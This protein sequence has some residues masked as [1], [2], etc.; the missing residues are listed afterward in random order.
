MTTRHIAKC[1]V[2]A[3]AVQNG[4]TLVEL[5]VALAMVVILTTVAVPSFRGLTIR[6]RLE[7]QTVGLA[8]DL[9]FARTEAIRRGATVV[10]CPGTATNCAGSSWNAERLIFVNTTG[11][12]ESFDSG[13]ILLRVAAAPSADDTLTAQTPV[14]S[15][16]FR[17][18]GTTS[19]AVSFQTCHPGFTG[20]SFTLRRI[21]SV[22]GT[23]SLEEPCQ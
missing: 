6:N 12:T 14:E 22:S 1:A 8:A 13:D 2:T 4:F 10:V 9:T 18:D 3:T 16:Q 23:Q 19:A 11:A 15:V 5:L 21:G 7:A 20:K 17:P